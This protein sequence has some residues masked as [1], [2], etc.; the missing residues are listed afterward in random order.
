MA[1]PMAQPEQPISSDPRADMYD[2]YLSNTKDSLIKQLAKAGMAADPKAKKADLVEQLH[3]ARNAIASPPSVADA[4]AAAGIVPPNP[5]SAGTQPAQGEGFPLPVLAAPSATLPPGLAEER[6]AE[7][8]LAEALRAQ[9][10]AQ[11]AASPMNSPLAS[12]LYDAITNGR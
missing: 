8:R 2:T 12:R 5:W 10:F 4:A 7:Q 11:A 3:A 9:K 6:L 1:L